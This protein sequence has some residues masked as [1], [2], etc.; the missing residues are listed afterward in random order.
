M[1]EVPHLEDIRRIKSLIDYVKP[2]ID[3]FHQIFRI[4]SIAYAKVVRYAACVEEGAELLD[5]ELTIFALVV[6]DGPV[7]ALVFLVFEKDIV[8]AICVDVGIE[9][10]ICLC[11]RCLV[12]TCRVQV[13]VVVHHPM[14]SKANKPEYVALDRIALYFPVDYWLWLWNFECPER[15]FYK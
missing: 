9:L 4:L 11:V 3:L 12:H 5:A 6:L 15:I 14:L 10:S 1:H 8:K 2:T 7:F 13:R